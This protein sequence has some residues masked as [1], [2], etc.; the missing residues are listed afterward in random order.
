MRHSGVISLVMY[1]AW[2][3]L[4]LMIEKETHDISIYADISTDLNASLEHHHLQPVIKDVHD[5]L[6]KNILRN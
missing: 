4:T 3:T 5:K 2:K 6:M 1:S